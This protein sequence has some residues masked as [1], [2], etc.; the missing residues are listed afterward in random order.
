[1]LFTYLCTS[2]MHTNWLHNTINIPNYQNW[3]YTMYHTIL[4]SSCA[5]ARYLFRHTRLNSLLLPCTY[6]KNTHQHKSLIPYYFFFI[7]C[8]NK[9]RL[10]HQTGKYKCKD[11]KVVF[12]LFVFFCY[13][14]LASNKRKNLQNFHNLKKSFAKRKNIIK[15]TK[16]K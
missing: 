13:P 6:K 15:S 1:M 14:F 12:F 8:L 4:S 11:F 16:T 5:P 9:R 10:V 7:N 2:K 3:S